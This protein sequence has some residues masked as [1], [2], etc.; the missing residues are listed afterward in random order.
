[1]EEMKTVLILDFSLLTNGFK[2]L[3]ILNC[4]R[5]GWKSGL[6]QTGSSSKRSFPNGSCRI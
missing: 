6:T 1:M 5:V 4:Y 3:D 2:W